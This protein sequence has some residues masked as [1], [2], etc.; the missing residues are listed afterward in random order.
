[1]QTEEIKTK[2]REQLGEQVEFEGHFNLVV[3]HMGD[4][5]QQH[6]LEWV[7]KC[8]HRELNPDQSPA[9]FELLAFFFKP[10]VNNIR[11]I[12]TKRK[13][14]YFIALFLDKHKYYDLERRKLGFR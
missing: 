1:M 2:I 7:R 14:S 5:L 13:N 8:A 6:L 11:G 10:N 9:D 4:N 3:E 12:L